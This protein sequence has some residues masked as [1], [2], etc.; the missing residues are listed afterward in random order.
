[1]KHF[2]WIVP[3]AIVAG[4][5][6]ICTVDA[7]PPGATV[8]VAGTEV[9]GLLISYC[10]SS[11]CE[12][13]CADGIARTPPPTIVRAG[14]PAEARVVITRASV[15]ELH[16]RVGR[17]LDALAEIPSDRLTLASGVNVVAVS[18]WWDRGSTY[19]IFAI[20]VVPE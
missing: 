19:Y 4:L 3:L 10:W 6:G 15:R 5:F 9:Q 1:M 13:H 16:V 8:G 2:R 20:D 14:A 11:A 18:A 17:S 7:G 12:A